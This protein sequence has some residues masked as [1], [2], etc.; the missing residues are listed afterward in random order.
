MRESRFTEEQIVKALQEWEAG[1]KPSELVR[2]HRIT[3][4]TLYRLKRK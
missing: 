2:R 4:T 1:T 3:E